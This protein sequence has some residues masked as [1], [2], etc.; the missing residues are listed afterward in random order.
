MQQMVYTTFR[1]GTKTQGYEEMQRRICHK[2]NAVQ[3]RTL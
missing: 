2:C 3:E 1:T